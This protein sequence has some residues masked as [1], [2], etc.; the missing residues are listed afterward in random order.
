MRDVADV[1]IKIGCFEYDLEE[2]EDA[3]ISFQ[4]AHELLTKLEDTEAL[5]VSHYNLAITFHYGLNELEQALFHYERLE[6]MLAS[7][8]S[9]KEELARILRLKAIALEN[10]GRPEDAAE[11]IEKAGA[12]VM[13]GREIEIHSKDSG[14]PNVDRE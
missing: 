1:Y 11:A 7:N 9:D 2:F 10:L 4:I 12:L 6:S 5:Q 14:I 8:G 3:A 13:G